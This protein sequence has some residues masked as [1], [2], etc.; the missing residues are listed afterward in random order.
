MH[1]TDTHPLN[2]FNS[3]REHDD[4]CK[5]HYTEGLSINDYDERYLSEK[6]EWQ[7]MEKE[8]AHQLKLAS[9]LYMRR[10]DDGWRRVPLES[11]IYYSDTPKV[12]EID[13]TGGLPDTRFDFIHPGY[14]DFDSFVSSLQQRNLIDNIAPED[15]DIDD[16]AF[17]IPHMR[18]YDINVLRTIG[19]RT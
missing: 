14:S 18:P 16:F 11:S 7:P 6:D 12:L 15:I 9:T 2:W 5:H 17:D 8:F 13:V 19:H 10:C 1:A 3:I 4:H